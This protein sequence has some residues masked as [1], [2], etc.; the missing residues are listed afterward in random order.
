MKCFKK[1]LQVRFQVCK[2]V[3]IKTLVICTTFKKYIDNPYKW[4][5][6]KKQVPSL[7]LTPRTIIYLDNS[8][9]QLALFCLEAQGYVEFIQIV[10][11]PPRLLSLKIQGSRVRSLPL[12][13]SS[14]FLCREFCWRYFH[15]FSTAGANYCMSVHGL[16]N[17][18]CTKIVKGGEWL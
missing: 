16:Y 10:T 4:N 5:T 17:F 6:R 11:V 12:P 8:L 2:V 15:I 9:V 14:A 3:I 13:T 18:V 7:S 1:N